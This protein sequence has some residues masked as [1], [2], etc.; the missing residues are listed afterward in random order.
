MER[1]A[2]RHRHRHRQDKGLDTRTYRDTHE[3]PT[4]SAVG[5]RVEKERDRSWGLEGGRRGG[6]GGGEGRKKVASK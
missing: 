6:E 2:G 4:N 3:K 1:W 5:T